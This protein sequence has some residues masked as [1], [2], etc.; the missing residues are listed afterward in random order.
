[1]AAAMYEC[2]PSR[3][4]DTYF[5]NPDAIRAS[6]VADT[7]PVEV[8]YRR[9]RFRSDV[10]EK[11]T[12]VW[13]PEYHFSPDFY[14][15]Q[16]ARYALHGDLAVTQD[17][18]GIAMSH[19]ARWITTED[20]VVD[21]HGKVDH[22][23]YRKPVV[24]TDF[25]VPFEA[26]LAESP[27]REIQIRWARLLMFDLIKMGFNIVS[28]TFDGFQS[29]DTMQI[30]QS[31]GVESSR[32]SM[33]L[34]DENWKTWRDVLYEGRYEMPY[35]QRLMD[36]LLGLS[37]FPGGKVDHVPG[38]SKDEADA[39]CGSVVGALLAGG[40]EDPAGRRASRLFGSAIEVV[41]G[42]FELPVG[43]GGWESVTVDSLMGG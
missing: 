31:H 28:F 21:E 41:P 16:G 30:L 43:F 7:Q 36:E 38:G 5:R 22:V 25:V 27:A 11:V 42:E 13:E 1:M 37:R 14:P 10:T 34:T 12:E 23:G 40:E 15:I 6:I 26:N 2:R 33:D 9:V 35:S 4:L 39:V 29:V 24:R 32:L 19:V 8:S 3:A 18:A 17:R 20:T